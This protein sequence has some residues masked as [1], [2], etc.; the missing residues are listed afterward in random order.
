[1][2]HAGSGM[3][4]DRELTNLIRRKFAIKCTTG[5]SLNALVDFP[6]SDP[7]EIAK[8]LLVG[9]EGT[10]GFVSRAT[11]NTVPE[12][13]H[14]ASA[15]MVFPDVHAACAAAAM[16]RDETAVDA[17]E[18]FDRRAPLPPAPALLDSCRFACCSML[19]AWRSC[20][21]APCTAAHGAMRLCGVA[22]VLVLLYCPL[23]H[24]LPRSQMQAQGQCK[25]T[26]TSV[27]LHSSFTR[28]AHALQGVAARVREQRRPL[29]PRRTQGRG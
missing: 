7:V 16:L 18:L 21:Q 11:Y 17:V 28:A 27:A 3:Q 25:G 8:R 1:M 4:A 24:I 15:F 12:W 19:A 5:Y 29:Q 14:K 10:L 20:T 26:P 2:Q 6:A 22:S 9:S 23:A 13:P